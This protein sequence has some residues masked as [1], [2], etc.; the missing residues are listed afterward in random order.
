MMAMMIM[1]MMTQCFDKFFQQEGNSFSQAGKTFCSKLLYKK[2]IHPFGQMG[3]QKYSW[4]WSIC[5][6]PAPNETLM[7]IAKINNNCFL[8]RI[9]I[10]FSRLV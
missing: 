7:T 3:G 2:K 5:K 8:Y 9:S 10:F 1:M 4:I 6:C